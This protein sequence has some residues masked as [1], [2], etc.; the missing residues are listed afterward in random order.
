MNQE[1]QKT[2]KTGNVV[3][4]KIAMILG[5]S[6]ALAIPLRLVSTQ[7]ESRKAYEQEARS[8]VARG[9]GP[10]TNFASPMWISPKQSFSISKAETAFHL[11]SREKKRGLFRVPV[12][13]AKFKT[14]FQLSPIGTPRTIEEIKED[15]NPTS[16]LLIPMQGV[17]GVQN[18][19][20]MD[21]TLGQ[22]LKGRLSKR[23]I[24]IP[25]EDPLK[26]GLLT[27]KFEAELF[28]RGTGELEYTSIAG[29]EEIKM[30]GNWP[31]P[32][33]LDSELPTDLSRSADG[34]EAHWNLV[35]LPKAEDL[36]S[37]SR[38]IGIS[39]LWI[40]TDY[41]MIERATKYGILF[42]VLTFLLVF[43]I[44]Y[45][46][47]FRIHP[48][49]YGLIGLSI[50]LFYLLLLAVSEVILFDLAYLVSSLAV[51]S[52]MGVY[53]RG[54]LGR[55]RFVRWVIAEQVLLSAFFYLLL[56]LEERALLIGAIGLF[57][58][59]GAFMV[60]TRKIDWYSNPARGTSETLASRSS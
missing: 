54:F 42:I 28:L 1:N 43:L 27:H 46:G 12:F 30:T 20:I 7:V 21:L 38:T 2:L 36:S 49:Q 11:D 31:K 57:A 8:A 13:Q 10:Q 29:V 6:I 33:F 4:R 44:E 25:I 50:S 3:T 58:S 19:R 39:H 23:G 48:L 16:Y 14:R 45:L 9:W 34:F 24:I 55:S 41:S 18:F 51:I 17:A 52:L 53:L 37:P 5:L 22:E 15:H 47:R 60:A 26:D 32:K 40:S 59:L 35:S 56:I